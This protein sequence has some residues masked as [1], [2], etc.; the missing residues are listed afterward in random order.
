MEGSSG[1][2][3][4]NIG[5]LFILVFL[6]LVV[7]LDNRF[8]DLAS[9]SNLQIQYNHGV[10][11]AIEAAMERLV[12]VDNGLEKKLN[13]EEAVKCFYDSLAI[14]FDV[15]DKRDLRK[16]LEG[17]VPV[18]GVILEDGFYLYYNKENINQEEKIVSKEFSEKIT[19]Q[20]YENDITYYFTLTDYIRLIDE[21]SKEFY[22][23]N[24]HDLARL[25][26]NS[27]MIDEMEYDR[28]RRTTIINI[29]TETIGRYINEH[30]KIANYYGINYHFSL[31]Y[32]E[33]EDWYRTIDDISMI[34][35]FQG[36]PY[37][38]K[39][40][41]TYNRFAIAGARIHKEE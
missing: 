29:L 4:T 3:A 25:F 23:G 38:N 39:I 15:L 11:N 2:K 27:I 7:I 1:M 30:N 14:N 40:T 8:N 22:E 24:Y 36:Y 32:I 28:I 17:Y 18:I 9:I 26:P 35:F 12:E 6:C 5:L 34:A 31:P 33:M 10:D 21:N 20:Y 19:Y 41:G 16:Q 13:K 37:G